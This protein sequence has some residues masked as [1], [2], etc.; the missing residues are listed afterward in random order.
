MIDKID[1]VFRCTVTAMRRILLG[2]YGKPTIKARKHWMCMYIH[3][4]N[5][6]NASQICCHNWCSLARENTNDNERY[7]LQVH[8]KFDKKLSHLQN[9]VYE[10][11]VMNDCLNN[12]GVG[13]G[14]DRKRRDMTDIGRRTGIT[15]SYELLQRVVILLA[16][17]TVQWET[18]DYSNR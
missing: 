6:N 1:Q 18:R 5:A 17:D 2:T 12:L 4:K 15:A 7:A 16:G 10:S 9:S 3:T 11:Q 8:C 14:A 13:C